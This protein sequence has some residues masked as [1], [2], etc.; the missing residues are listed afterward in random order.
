M[1]RLRSEARLTLLLAGAL[2]APGCVP[3]LV[4]R[5]ATEASPPLPVWLKAGQAQARVGEHELRVR[6]LGTAGIELRSARAALVIDPYF[7]RHPLL[8]LLGGPVR[9]DE[10]AIARHMAPVDA[11]LV[12]HAHFD[13]FVDAPSVA[14]RARARLW[15]SPAALNLAA[16]EGVPAAQ[17]CA[18]TPHGRFTVGDIEVEAVPSRHSPM[19]TQW[20]AGG[21]LTGA[22][23]LPM[24][25]LAYKNDEVYG[26]ALHWRGRTLYHCGSADV[27]EAAVGSRRADVVFA[28]VS[29]WRSSPNVFR[30]LARTLQP[31]VLAPM[32]HDDFFRP[33]SEGVVENPLAYHEEAL[34]TMRRDA[35][36][37]ALLPLDFFDDHR[38]EARR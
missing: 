35:P 10:A 37:A 24:S 30:R 5:P 8:T 6:W 12:G 38:L 4:A 22:P 21:S 28:C 20:L 27:D 32:H 19:P 23:R 9:P 16:Q 2:L 26:F 36:D 29:G 7:S 3:R 15:A 31:R 33:F 14:R 13:H 25:F 17:L 11:V 18:L 1:S 34:R